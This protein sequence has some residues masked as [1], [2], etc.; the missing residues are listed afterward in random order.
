MS[1]RPSMLTVSRL[2]SVHSGGSVGFRSTAGNELDVGIIISPVQVVNSLSGNVAIGEGRSSV[3]GAG[4]EVA[5]VLP[6]IMQAGKRT[7]MIQVLRGCLANDM[8]DILVH[9]V[10]NYKDFS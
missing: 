6:I 9:S 4:R 5:I 10:V 2:N 8:M 7:T 3:F 1:E